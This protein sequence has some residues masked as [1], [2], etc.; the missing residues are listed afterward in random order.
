MDIEGVWVR[1]RPTGRDRRRTMRGGRGGHR[2]GQEQSAR[3]LAAMAEAAERSRQQTGS[4]ARPSGRSE[5][6]PPFTGSNGSGDRSTGPDA[7]GANGP[8]RRRWVRPALVTVVLLAAAAVGVA[9]AAPNGGRDA[10]S[11]RTTVSS[12]PATS[13]ATSVP[14]PTSTTVPTPPQSTTLPAP[15]SSPATVPPPGPSSTVATNPAP[16]PTG[17]GPVLTGMQPS[18]G[19]P[20]QVLVLTGSNLM[21]TSGQITAHFGGQATTIACPIANSCLVEVPAPGG[22]PA[23]APV[24]VTTD[25]GTSNPLTFTFG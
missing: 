16:A 21:S 22:S 23:T 1:A 14:S 5:D 15:V 4:P 6:A 20:G 17:G 7:D 25:A 13:S 18:S 12:V 9:V 11:S 3:A 24:T 19:A 8:F 2:S 10:S